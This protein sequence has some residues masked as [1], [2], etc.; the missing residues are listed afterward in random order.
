MVV[1]GIGPGR[2]GV[3][4]VDGGKV[5]VIVRPPRIGPCPMPAGGGVKVLGVE[6]V[7]GAE[8][9]VGVAVVE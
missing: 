8:K 5:G 6:L 7:G 1:G 4:M 2:F 3:R 9:C